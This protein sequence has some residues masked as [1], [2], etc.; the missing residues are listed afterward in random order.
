LTEIS[1]T[2]ENSPISNDNSI[3][4]LD[5]V[6]KCCT[7]KKIPESREKCID[8]LKTGRCR[9]TFEHTS[10]DGL[11][12]DEKNNRIYLIE[13]KN[14]EVYDENEISGKEIRDMDKYLD[15][16]K[17]KITE[18]KITEG[19]ITENE[20]DCLSKIFNKAKKEYKSKHA[21]NLKLKAYESIYSILPQ[22]YV[23]YCIKK[24]I[25]YDIK[26]YKKFLIDNEIHYIIIYKF[27]EED[28]ENKTRFDKQIAI[29][30]NKKNIQRIRDFTFNTVRELTAQSSEEFFDIIFGQTI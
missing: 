9:G 21:H 6:V 15:N 20:Y 19:K 1:S 30:C 4:C 2:G 13:F 27:P 18:G 8:C 5:D 12:I 25:E 16:I 24:D 26:E 22:M 23:E 14:I 17:R 28:N 10:T 11:Y 29:K 3:I 7:S